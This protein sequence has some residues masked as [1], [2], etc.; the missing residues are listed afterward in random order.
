ML[1]NVGGQTMQPRAITVTKSLALK[2]ATRWE[3]NFTDAFVFPDHQIQGV[4]YS[5]QIDDG[6]E[7]GTAFARHA[8]RAPNGQIVVVETDM[9][10]SGTVTLTATQGVFTS[11]NNW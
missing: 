5:M 6:G 8:S 2:A 4:R 3:F 10:V 1:G 7:G 11:G 9:P